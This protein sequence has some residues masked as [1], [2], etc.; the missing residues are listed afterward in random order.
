VEKLSISAPHSVPLIETRAI[1][2]S[3]R[4]LL[5]VASVDFDLAAGEVHGL[6][7]A[8]GAGK[9]TFTK[10]L[11][12][13]I[14]PDS[15]NIYLSGKEITLGSP[16]DGLALGIAGIHQELATVPKMSVL[17]NV[18]LGDPISKGFVIDRAAM[19]KRFQEI[20]ETFGLRMPA[21]TPAGNLSVA[22]RQKVEI[23]KTIQ[24]GRKIL[25]MDEPTAALDPLDRQALYNLIRRLAAAGS[26][27]IFI[28]HDL[29]EVLMVCSRVSVMRDGALIDTRPVSRWTIDTLVAAMLGSAPQVKSGVRE[30]RTT[31]DI[32]FR[33]RNISVEGRVDDISF[34]VRRGEILGVAG[35]V[36]SGRSELLRAIFGAERSATG[37]IEINGKRRELPHSVRDALALGIVMVPEDRKLQGL[38]LGRDGYFNIALSNLSRFSRA[39]VLRWSQMRCRFDKAADDVK[40]AARRLH[41]EVGK[42][43]GGNQQKVLLAKWIVREPLLLLLDEPSRGVD[44]AA[45]AEIYSTIAMLASRGVGIVLVSSDMDEVIQN[46]DRVIVLQAGSCV[47]VLSRDEADLESVLKLKFSVARRQA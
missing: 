22:N 25:L 9:S 40:L 30:Q 35:L 45:R 1:C 17:S 18:F 11:S 15:G 10:I 34:Y 19:A 21:N 6:V 47:G 43:S 7:G 8:N 33:A 39:G 42:L 38:V 14:R 36:G 37:Q 4:G 29:D 13:A 2:K 46:S 41:S 12:G 27:I 20:S 31:N 32:V 28:S 5:A 24:A 23:L 3:Y 44:V 26:S 16:R